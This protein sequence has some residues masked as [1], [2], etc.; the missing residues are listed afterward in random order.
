MTD[1]FIPQDLLAHLA[2]IGMAEVDGK[3]GAKYWVNI[4]ILELAM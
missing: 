2:G 1:C 4:S 3:I